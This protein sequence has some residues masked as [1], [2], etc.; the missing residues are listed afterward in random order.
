MNVM[1]WEGSWL[2]VFSVSGGYVSCNWVRSCHLALWEGTEVSQIRTFEWWCNCSEYNLKHWPWPPNPLSAV[3]CS[4]PPHC[5]SENSCGSVRRQIQSRYYCD[6]LIVLYKRTDLQW[7]VKNTP[8]VLYHRMF[9]EHLPVQPSCCIFCPFPS[10]S[11]FFPP[12]TSGLLAVTWTCQ[13]NPSSCAFPSA[14]DALPP[15]D[16]TFL[17]LA[18]SRALFRCYRTRTACPG[19]WNTPASLLSLSFPF[20]FFPK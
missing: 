16:Y 13:G 7:T 8:V 5:W 1:C 2:K 14:W 11:T 4:P 20:P 17:S 19:D 6:I 3:Q 10:F 9:E 12:C 15:R 18:S